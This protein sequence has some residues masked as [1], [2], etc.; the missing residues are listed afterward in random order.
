M[1]MHRYALDF[2]A[3]VKTI[4]RNNYWIY[5]AN[6]KSFIRNRSTDNLA[7]IMYMHELALVSLEARGR[8]FKKL[9]RETRFHRLRDIFSKI[10]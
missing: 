10:I 3:A 1:R 5:D 2:K 7:S 4:V 6:K 8:L 9:L